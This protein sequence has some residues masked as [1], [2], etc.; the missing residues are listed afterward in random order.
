MIQVTR[1]YKKKKET[2]VNSHAALLAPGAI[3]MVRGSTALGKP[4]K[5]TITLVSGESVPVAETR[6]QI[7]ELLGVRV[8]SVP[9]RRR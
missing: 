7:Q 2:K 1:L 9:A 4:H 8:K 6:Q 3:A 5:A